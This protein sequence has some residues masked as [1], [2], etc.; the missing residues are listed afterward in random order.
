MAQLLRL[1][2]Q[3]RSTGGTGNRMPEDGTRTH[4]STMPQNLNEA[5]SSQSVYGRGHQVCVS[6]VTEAL[7]AI[8][9]TIQLARKH[10]P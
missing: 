8:S 10:S 1:P 3:G 9:K 5:S 7:S 4:S 6:S 2:K